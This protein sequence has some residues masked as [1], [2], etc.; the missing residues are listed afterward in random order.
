MSAPTSKRKQKSRLFNEARRAESAA[1]RRSIQ[2]D[3]GTTFSGHALGRLIEQ[4]LIADEHDTDNLAV[5]AHACR[6]RGPEDNDAGMQRRSFIWRGRIVTI[7][8]RVT[9]GN[10]RIVTSY[11][12]SSR[13]YRKGAPEFVAAPDGLSFS[14]LRQL[15]KA[16][17]YEIVPP[18][19]TTPQSV[20]TRTVTRAAK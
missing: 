4:S 19:P 8:V 1:R 7:V 12:S 10:R 11:S 16:L 15:A 2:F 18:V 14:E 13:W 5:I 20:T 3:G 6:L 17:K 9:S